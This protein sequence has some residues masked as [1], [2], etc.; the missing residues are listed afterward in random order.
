MQPLESRGGARPR[1]RRPRPARLAERRQR[2]GLC[3]EHPRCPRRGRSRRRRRY[4]ANAAAYLAKLDALEREV[5]G[6]GRNDPAGPAQDHHLARRLR[7]FRARPTGLTSSRPRASR[8]RP[9]PRPRTWPG[10]SGRSRAR[11]SR[12]CSSRTS[13]I[14]RLIERIAQGERRADRRQALLRRPLAAGRPGRDLHRHD[15]AQYK[16]AQ[17]GAVVRRACHSGARRRREPGNHEHGA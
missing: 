1:P 2:Q 6:G 9:K 3:D 12:P 15:A 13:P 7:L 16:G 4:E 17:R 11:R 8:P 5:T 14:P 10:S